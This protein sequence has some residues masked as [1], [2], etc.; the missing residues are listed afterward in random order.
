MEPKRKMAESKLK[1]QEREL[2]FQAERDAVELEN[3]KREMDF[4]M[5]RLALDEMGSECGS[6]V[7]SFSLDDGRNA[8]LKNWLRALGNS[9]LLGQM[10]WIVMI[11]RK[12][13]FVP[14]AQRLVGK[15]L[16][17]MR[18]SAVYRCLRTH[19]RTKHNHSSLKSRGRKI[20][21]NSKE[22]LHQLFH[23]LESNRFLHHSPLR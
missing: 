12:K 1:Q 2:E 7:A 17:R 11:L 22:P 15:M 9:T 13:C 18:K 14:V 19:Y 16:L 8:H 6:S 10:N 4:K 3:Y 5:K 21:E 20:T 23:K